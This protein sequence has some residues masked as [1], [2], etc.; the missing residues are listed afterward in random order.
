[1]TMK[2]RSPILILTATILLYSSPWTG[3]AS[4]TT[5]S[6]R[7]AEDAFGKARRSE[8]AS[9]SPQPGEFWPVTRLPFSFVYDGRSSEALL[10]AWTRQATSQDAADRSEHSVSWTEA[11]TGLKVSAT[12]TAFKD[13]PAVE[14]VLRFENT[15]A[16]DTPILEKVQVL[17]ASLSAAALQTVLLDQINGDDCSERS[18]APV[19]RELKPGQQVALAPVGGRPSNGTFPFFNVQQG[20]RGVFI[21]I[22]WTGQWAASLRRDT[23]G[24]V[25][26]QAG[27]ELTHLRLHP[28]ESIRTPRILLLHWSGDRTEAHN[29][30]R[31]L[32]LAHYLPKLDG[33]PVS[34]AIAA[35]SFNRWAGGTRPVWATE[36]GQIAAAKV[37]RDLGCDT[38]WFDAGWFEGNFPNGVGNWFPKPKEFPNGLKPVGEACEKLGLKFLVW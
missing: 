10:D 2:N 3:A 19:E 34:L 1:M 16:G 22:G 7:W 9:L 26:L 32:L 21:A 38:L 36:A 30:F 12:A 33:Q 31:R 35:Q 6:L 5:A 17:D 18:F 24:S 25:R 4:L 14:W 28:G 8:P 13:F 37:D 27:M 15:G 23:N 20:D 29:Q 11:A